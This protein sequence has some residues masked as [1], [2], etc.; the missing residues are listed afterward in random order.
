MHL[1]DALQRWEDLAR[2]VLAGDRVAYRQA[3][4]NHWENDLAGIPSTDCQKAALILRGVICGDSTPR[5]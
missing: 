1:I 3:K 2:D 5:K 4:R